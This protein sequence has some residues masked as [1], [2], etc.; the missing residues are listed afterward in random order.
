MRR[1]AIIGVTWSFA[2]I[3]SLNAAETDS[4]ETFTQKHPQEIQKLFQKLDLSRP[5]LKNISQAVEKNHWQKACEEL[6]NYYRAR[7]PELQQH[8]PPPSNQRN[9]NVDR[10]LQNQFTIQGI[11]ATQPRKPDG[12]LDWEDQGPKNDPEWAW[13]LNRHHFFT[14]LLDAWRQTGN[15]D[16]AKG[17]NR[18]IRDWI[19]SNPRPLI[20]KDSG[21]WRPMEAGRRLSDIWPQIF[22]GFQQAPEFGDAARLM[23]LISI[24]QQADTCLKHHTSQGNHLNA[25]MAGLASAAIYWPEFKDSKHWLDNAINTTRKEFS[26]R[27]YPDG[28]QQ[29]LSNHYQVIVAKHIDRMTNL[30]AQAYRP[31][32]KEFRALADKLWNYVSQITKPDGYGPLNNDGDLENNAQWLRDAATLR[33]LPSW[34]DNNTQSIFFPWAGHIIM[35]N[36]STPASDWLF[37]DAGPLGAAH[38]HYDKLHLSLHTSGHDVLV[39]N[40]R[41]TYRSGNWRRH[42]TGPQSHNTLIFDNAYP[43]QEPAVSQK[44]VPAVFHTS[45]AADF[46]I[47]QTNY[48][49][50]KILDEC[51]HKRAVV[52]VKNEYWLIVDE[53]VTFN[54]HK[55]S[56]LWHFHPDCILKM[57]ENILS[58]A[59]NI[60]TSARSEPLGSDPLRSANGAAQ[61]QPSAK[62]WKKTSSSPILPSEQLNFIPVGNQ[63]W[64]LQI[65][66]GQQK[67][68]IQ[69]WYS[70]KYN[71]KQPALAAI[72]S[73]SI[74]TP[75]IFGWIISKGNPPKKIECLSAKNG[76]LSLRITHPDNT[77]DQI[78]LNTTHPS[79]QIQRNGRIFA[80]F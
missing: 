70:P 12:R 23:M 80:S 15:P 30:L 71:K 59:K 41:Y 42:F 1:V 9:A 58:I 57:K 50:S 68:F 46:A 48:L 43:P 64:Q 39:D 55:I 21:A 32:K 33:N 5:E 56:V 79:C 19:E 34:P 25:E 75:A 10:I 28:A 49:T 35:R 40:G 22:Y 74:R 31:E 2:I 3:S 61:N 17:F 62:R 47:A 77:L 72:Y 78:T 54:P 51:T 76:I 27:V 4:L 26:Q 38:Q 73:A 24:W 14:D 7:F 11:T 63:N 36:S 18:Y 66:K 6:L 44:P 29:E 67:P 16:Y 13:M 69:G 45:P 65:I 52:Y 53:A 8:P 20:S 37:F 60:S